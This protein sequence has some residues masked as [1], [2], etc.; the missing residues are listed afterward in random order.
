MPL[1]LDIEGNDLLDGVTRIHCIVTKDT[2]TGEVR[3]FR[4]HSPVGSG[5]SNEEGLD[6]ISKA[7]EVVTF[8]GLGYDIPALQKVY[9]HFQFKGTNF[10]LYVA[11][12]LIWTN[13][14]EDD[15]KHRRLPANLWGLQKLEAWGYR[16]GILKGTYGKQDNAWEKWSQQMEDYCVQDVAVTEAL[17]K[18]ILSKKYSP[19]ALQLEHDFKKVI[20]MQER[21]GWA[22]D[23][24][25]A[26]K[27]AAKLQGDRHDLTTKLQAVFPPRVEVMKTPAYYEVGGQQFPTKTAASLYCKVK[28]NGAKL[29]DIKAG[30]LK[31]KH[32]PFNPGSRDQIAARLIAKYGWK[33][34]KFTDSGKVAIDE[35][36]L[37]ALS[38]P[39]AEMLGDYLIIEK[40][41]G[42]LAEG[43]GAVMKLVKN[44]RVHGGV[45]TNGAVTGRCTHMRPNIAQTP[46]VMMGK[47]AEGKKVPVLGLDGGYG[48]EFR[49]LYGAD[50][51]QVMCGW[52]ASGLELRCL[53]HYLR[54]FDGGKFEQI[55]LEGDVH[56]ENQKNAGFHLRNSAKTFIYAY[57]YGAGDE[58]L[59]KIAVQD[60]LDAGK[61]KP[62]GTLKSIG[63]A[64][65]D[66]FEQ[67]FRALKLLKKGIKAALQTR[68]YLVGLDGRRLHVRSDHA[69]LNTLLQ[70]A[71]ALLM[72]KALVFQYE[73][74][75]SQ[76]YVFGKDFAF[77]G[78]VHD[79][80]QT[81]C[82]PDISDTVGKSGPEALRKAGEYFE[83]RCRLDGEYK[84]GPHWAATH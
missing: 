32:H 81:T 77:V 50:P 21:H 37:A 17:Y 24:E 28:T 74:L 35:A 38:W 58:K 14:W 1:L 78:N 63:T 68:S 4:A 82:R 53:A 48:W 49:S 44:G 80:V 54:P 3:R 79:E 20:L 36:V 31:E 30:P 51:D 55:I 34:K 71:G 7:A 9:P 52:D 57:L 60:C 11:A 84:V 18:L 61:P 39:E 41:L 43:Q 47:D 23:V 5:C 15:S 75:T 66:R 73:F 45:N 56:T 27:V 29:A 40:T 12:N 26:S 33:P 19:K 6:L 2:Q 69:A 76:G 42:Q 72:K 25:G 67:N 59:G 13:L 65:R 70:S 10:D 22:F 83:F 46:S 62:T 64:L 16:L 8:N